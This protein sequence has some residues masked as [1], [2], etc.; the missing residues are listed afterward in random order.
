MPE[1]NELRKILLAR[2]QAFP[3]EVRRQWDAAICAHVLGWH[4]TRRVDSLGVYRPIRG[5][6]DLQDLYQALAERGVQLSLPI[7]ASHDAPLR[8]AAWSPGDR[9]VKDA[10]GVP[11]PAEIRAVAQPHA[12]LIP[13]VGFNP[14]RVRLGY[15]GGFYDRTLAA[16][17]GAY[18]IGI[19]YSSL[20][21]AFEAAA[22]DMPLDLIIT[23]TGG[24]S[25]V[26]GESMGRGHQAR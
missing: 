24:T 12:V 14:D 8:F 13:C 9:L 2:R 22:H 21:A 16:M 3:A 15:G 11:V 25:G 18:S 17:P 5:E 1:K 10:L 23:E 19:A 20:A 7:V 4:A 6:P 26:G